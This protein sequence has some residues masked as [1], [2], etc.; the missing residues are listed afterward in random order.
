LRCAR[1]PAG[2]GAA[3][4]PHLHVVGAGHA[5]AGPIICAPPHADGGR[6]AGSDGALGQDLW[7]CPL[8]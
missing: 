6:A 2:P 1:Q 5:C 8:V 3:V 4:L 7:F